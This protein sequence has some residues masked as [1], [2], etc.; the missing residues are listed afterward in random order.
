MFDDVD[1]LGPTGVCDGGTACTPATGLCDP[2]PDPPASMTCESDGSPCT[3]DHC[4]GM[5]NCV[6]LMQMCGACCDGLTGL[7]SENVVEPACTCTHCSWTQGAT[8]DQTPCTEALGACCDR[9]NGP[10][11]YNST[12][13]QCACAQCNWN[14]GL[15][16][17]TF[18]CPE[19][20]PIPTVSEWGLVVLSLL[21]LTGGKI[22]FSR[23]EGLA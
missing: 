19:M 8:C 17:A 15:D 12:Q 16:C 13:D 5:G 3:V 9:T 22:Y 4:D 23:R 20:V 6:V 2:L 7:C 21:L 1:C 18:Q 10:T 14:K 11:C